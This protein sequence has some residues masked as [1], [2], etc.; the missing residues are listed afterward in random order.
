MTAEGRR[1]GGRHRIAVK[2]GDFMNAKSLLI[3]I[4]VGIAL[5]GATGWL[6][7][8]GLMLREY[9]SPLGV[10]ETVERIKQN[11]L[12]EGWVVSSVMPL[13]DSIK[14]HGGGELPPVRLVNLCQA[15]HAFKILSADD[16]KV[17]SV[18]MPCTIGVYQKSDG[19]TYVGT[20]NAGLLGRA[21][22]G[23]V[24]R[25]MGGDVAEAQQRFISFVHP[26][27]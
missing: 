23:V 6:L 5:A 3:G 9:P 14:Q 17:V 22:G 7:T 8:P 25:V 4:V 26:S 21:F 15:Q 24:A 16:N 13:N 12:A 10:E 27:R 20:M 19:K 1:R 18:M 2:R 11:A